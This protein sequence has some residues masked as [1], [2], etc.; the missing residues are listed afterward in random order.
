MKLLLA[1]L[2]LPGLAQAATLTVN[3]Q[4]PLTCS[5]GTPLSGC[6]LTKYTVYSGLSGATK[7]VLSTT[8]PTVTTFAAVNTGP[9]NWCVQ[10]SA[11][12]AGGESALSNEVCKVIAAPVPGVPGNVTLTVTVASTTAYTLGKSPGLVVMLPYGTVPAGSS[13][14]PAQGVFVNGVTYNVVLG[15]VTSTGSVKTV[16]PFARCS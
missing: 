2:L 11:S 3:W 1:L 14:D 16:T 13:C 7:T 6:A 12:S 8:L 4:P 10:V 9:G 5:D 15:T